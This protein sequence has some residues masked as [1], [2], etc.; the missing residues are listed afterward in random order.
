LV[1][2]GIGLLSIQLPIL[3]AA[4]GLVDSFFEL[5]QPANDNGRMA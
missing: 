1:R 5:R 3:V 4:L 2:W